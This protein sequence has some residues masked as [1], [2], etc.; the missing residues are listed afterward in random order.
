MGLSF[1]APVG[2]VRGPVA[3]RTLM[4]VTAV[5]LVV[6]PLPSVRA[7]A[8]PLPDDTAAAVADVRLL[9]SEVASLDLPRGDRFTDSDL[10][11]AITPP[12]GWMQ[13]PVTA[14]NPLSDPPEPVQESARFQLRIQDTQLYATPIPITSGL[15]ADAGALISIGVARVGSDILDLDRRGRGTRELGSVA[16]FTVLGISPDQG[17]VIH[18]DVHRGLR[19]PGSGP[20]ATRVPRHG[21]QGVGGIRLR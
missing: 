6:A 9:P 20:G 12:G 15:V 8:A 1:S 2:A 4:A 14:L 17:G 13:S 3:Q 18:P 11:L 16:G 10:A 7:A 5:L 21:H 19:S